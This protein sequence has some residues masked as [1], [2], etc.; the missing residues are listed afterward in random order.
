MEN[1]FKWRHFQPEVILLCVRRHLRYTLSYRDLEEMMTERG[2]SL[3]HT[4]IYRWVQEYAPE[5]DKHSRPFLKQT[6]DSW[7]V[8]E[9][10]VKVRG[11]WMYLYRAVDSTGQTLDFLLKQIRSTRAVKRFFRNVLGQPNIMS[12]RVINVDKNGCYICAVSDLKKAGLL[13]EKCKR[14]P[15]RYMNNMVEQDHRFLKRRIKPGLGFGSYPTAW[16]TIQ[17][18]ETMHM[19]RK[20]RIAGVGR[21]NIQAQNQF[22]AGLFGLDA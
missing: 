10:Y 7:R 3:D 5:L 14:R 4:T 20:G 22:I 9:T 2:L 15:S 16:R 21:G 18:Y 1:P 12:P 17:G 19:I 8:D 6:N 13:P 11:K